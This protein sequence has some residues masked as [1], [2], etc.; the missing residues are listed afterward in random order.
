MT[1]QATRVPVPSAVRTP[2]RVVDSDVH[3]VPRAG[4]L[5]PYIPEPYRS[6]YYL[7]QKKGETILYDAPDYAYAKAMRVDT[8]PEDGNFA[9][10]DPNLMLRQEIVEG[11]SD[12][13]VRGPG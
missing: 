2:I 11:G 5:A 9:G 7:A 3:P 1:V 12:I 10:S 6:K 8:F 4:E 13:C